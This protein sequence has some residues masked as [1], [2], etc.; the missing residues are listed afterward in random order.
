MKIKTKMKGRETYYYVETDK[1][2]VEVRF[3]D[4]HKQ[5]TAIDV[6]AWRAA[7]IKENQ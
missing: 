4:W 2:E 1:G 5:K 6:S 3:E 7:N